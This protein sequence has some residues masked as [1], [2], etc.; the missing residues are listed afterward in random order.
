MALDRQVFLAAVAAMAA[1][2]ELPTEKCGGGDSG[3]TSNCITDTG[4]KEG[5]TTDT[6]PTPTQE[7]YTG[8]SY[9]TTTYGYS[10]GYGYSY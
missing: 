3:S 4:T 1:G 9:G 8:Y 10:Y 7:G 5:S 2:C 6:D